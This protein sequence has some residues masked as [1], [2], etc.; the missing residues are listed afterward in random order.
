MSQTAFYAYR[1]REEVEYDYIV[2]LSA[3]EISTLQ[4]NLP[5]TCRK[6]GLFSVVK[7]SDLNRLS[8]KNSQETIPA[9]NR[10]LTEKYL[11][12]IKFFAA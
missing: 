11:T 7:N 1:N 8:R 4:V 6:L 10:D 12:N 3:Q 2:L 5:F 9:L